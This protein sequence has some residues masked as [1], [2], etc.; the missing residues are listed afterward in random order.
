MNTI[1]SDGMDLDW[2]TVSEVA[3]AQG[4][5]VMTQVLAITPD[6]LWFVTAWVQETPHGV[7]CISVRG[8][9]PPGVEP[10]DL[11]PWWRGHQMAR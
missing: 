11:S 8:N 10:E 1:T 4:K 5:P 9:L 7:R 6:E 3:R 2:E